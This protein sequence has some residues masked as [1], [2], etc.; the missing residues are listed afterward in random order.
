MISRLQETVTT[1]RLIKST[2]PLHQHSRSSFF[3]NVFNADIR[4]FILH[5]FSGL[6]SSSTV[7]IL[8]QRSSTPPNNFIFDDDDHGAASESYSN[9]A[10]LRSP[11]RCFGVLRFGDDGAM[12]Q[13]GD[14]CSSTMASTLLLCCVSYSDFYRR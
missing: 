7:F 12:I 4:V 3:I 6:H 8:H 2:V 1:S 9:M 10:L 13:F 11:T 14:D 5:A